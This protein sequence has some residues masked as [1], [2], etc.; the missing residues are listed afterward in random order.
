MATRSVKR[1]HHLE[2]SIFPRLAVSEDH[3]QLK[4]R[5]IKKSKVGRLI[6][7]DQDNHET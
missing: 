3:L 1:F 7:E 5:K 4:I 6:Y 2:E